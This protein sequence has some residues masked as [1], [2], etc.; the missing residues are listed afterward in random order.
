MPS[1]PYYYI[2]QKRYANVKK[3][4]RIYFQLKVNK[5]YARTTITYLFLNSYS[6]KDVCQDVNPKELSYTVGSRRN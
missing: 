2:S 6:V 5:I 1:A 3:Y 4:E